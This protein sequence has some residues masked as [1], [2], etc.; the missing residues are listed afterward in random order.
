MPRR[1]MQEKDIRKIRHGFG[2]VGNKI[3]QM[4]QELVKLKT[5]PQIVAKEKLI[6]QMRHADLLFD[7]FSLE[8]C[9]KVRLELRDL[10]QYIPDNVQHY[11]MNIKDFVIDSTDDPAALSHVQTY[12]E[13]A[14]EYL[15]KPTPA[16]AKLRNLDEL[17][18]EEKTELDTVFKTKLGSV[19]DYAAW[20]GNKPLLP[21]LR[22]QVGIANEA[23]QTKF[24]TILNSAASNPAQLAY[25]NQIINYAREN[26]DITFM[27]LQQVSP[28]CDVDIMGLFGARLADIKTLIN[29]LH[30]P[31]M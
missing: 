5:I 18:E 7:S 22:S 17:T 8:Q 31:I 20:S 24:G 3:D 23:I 1:E 10:M 15:E 30:K 9:E 2:N 12:E 14:K 26:G 28:F 29:G 11:V 4:M 21:F 27:D 16:L 6:Q 25:M 13:K 19:A